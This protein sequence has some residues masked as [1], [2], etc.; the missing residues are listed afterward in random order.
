[1]KN[2]VYFSKIRVISCIAIVFLHMFY[3]AASG[4]EPTFVQQTV[5]MIV[6]NCL[7][8]AV[9]CFVMVS[10]ALL[11]DPSREMTIGKIFGK[12]V[13]RIL[14]ALII[15]TLIYAVFD[16]ALSGEAFGLTFVKDWLL[17]LWTNGSWPHVWYLYMVLG[18][19]LMLPLYRMVTAYREPAS[20]YLAR[21]NDTILRY[22]VMVFFLFLSVLPTI[23]YLTGRTSGFYLMSYTVYPFYFFMG[24]A[25]HTGKVRI[26]TPAAAVMLLAGTVCLIAATYYGIT[27]QS[28][29]LRNF[30]GSYASVAVAVQSVGLFVLFVNRARKTGEMTEHTGGAAG[31]P[32]AWTL[33]ADALAVVEGTSISSENGRPAVVEVP[34]EQRMEEAAAAANGQGLAEDIPVRKPGFG[35]KLLLS[36]DAASFGIYL[37]HMIVLN[38]FYRILH[39]NPY[40]MGGIG[41]LALLAAVN[42]LISWGVVTLLRLIPGVKKVL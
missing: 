30:S 42:V 28:D 1:M 14:L 4:F 3:L 36:F 22:A 17:R 40:T 26:P 2:V 34:A 37:V 9:P 13:R 32:D 16:R 27:L 24:Y 15:F 11:L 23:A 7:L 10:G 35:R 41:M 21:K 31:M 39:W 12:Y 5:S 8:W 38:V 25:L 18:L 29:A 33:P 19:Y 20:G 6:R